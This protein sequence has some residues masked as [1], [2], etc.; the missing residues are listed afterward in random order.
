MWVEL[1][2]PHEEAGFSTNIS[3]RIIRRNQAHAF[4]HMVVYVRELCHVHVMKFDS[5]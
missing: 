3:N 5:A 4:K 2:L 1:Y